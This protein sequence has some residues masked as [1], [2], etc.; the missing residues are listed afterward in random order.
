MGTIVFLLLLAL[1]FVKFAGKV[2]SK[3]S[4]SAPSR[5]TEGQEYVYEEMNDEYQARTVSKS[6]KAAESAQVKSTD[7]NYEKTFKKE[8]T[9]SEKKDEQFSLRKAVIY[10][11]ILDRPYK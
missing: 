4:S 5:R 8:K 11:A 1:V 3:E 7:D 2:N 10:S 9:P 6:S